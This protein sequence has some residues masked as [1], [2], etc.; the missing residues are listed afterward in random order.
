LVSPTD[1]GGTFVRRTPLAVL[2]LLLPLAFAAEAPPAAGPDR[3]PVDLVLTPDG[4]GILTVNQTSGTVSLLRTATGQIVA[5]AAV[6]ERPSA[7]ALT[8]DAGRVLVTTTYGGELVVLQRLN[9]KLERVGSV[10]LGFEPR[11]V[12]VAP[13]GKRAYVALTTA[14]EVAV[15]DLDKMAVES[16]I[17]VGRWPRYLALTPDGKRLAVGV[18]GDGGVAVVDTVERKQLFIEDFVG[19]N[20]GQMQTSPDGKYVYVPWMVYRHNPITPNNI[21]LGWVLASRIARVRL[22]K[23]ARREAISLDPQ[24]MA[25]SDPHGIGVSPDGQ[26]LACAAS[27]THELLMYRLEGLPFV[28]YGGPGDHI[29]AKL[30]K[31]NQRFFRIP[32]GGRPMALRW[33][34]DGRLVY[35]ANYLLNAVQVVDP[36]GRKIVRTLPLGGPKEP[37]LVRKGEAIFYDGQRSLDQWYSCHS[38]HYE[39]H[40]NAVAMD[41]RNDGRFGNFK[42]VLSLRHADRTGPYFWH[43]WEKDLGS[44]VGKSVTD[45]MLGKQPSADDVAALTAYLGTLKPPPN[46]YRAADGSL[47]ESAKRGAAVFNGDKAGCAKCHPAPL[48]TDGKV[49]SVGTNEP[50]DVYKGYNPPPLVG[51]YDRIKYLHHG[52]AKSLEELLTGPHAPE[53]VTNNGKLTKDELADLIAYLKSL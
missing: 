4:A 28:D 31:D 16:R 27:G 49:H 1:P 46:P 20:L 24:G 25:V 50:G 47:S 35:V 52:K 30:L 34:A 21:R 17:P 48:Y 39:G 14:H 29:E 37:S 3:S 23:P 32:L 2:L 42:T 19:L 7:L 26:W 43:G 6:G 12:T 13:D 45:S 10:R 41:T 15:V 36:A 38:C 33:S 44:A 5:E 22:D 40:T 51:V 8:P 53:K 18:N 11:G 9:D